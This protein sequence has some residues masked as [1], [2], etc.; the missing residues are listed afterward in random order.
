MWIVLKDF[1]SDNIY[2]NEEIA[3][4]T[5]ADSDESNYLKSVQAFEKAFGIDKFEKI[6]AETR[7]KR[8]VSIA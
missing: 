7:Y 6:I 8:N 5:Q 2:Q 3:D 1:N 4:A